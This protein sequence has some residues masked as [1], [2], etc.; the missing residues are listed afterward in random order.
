[1]GVILD[2][3]ISIR[4]ERR[5]ISPPE[6]LRQIEAITGSEPIGLSAIGITEVVHGIYRA[7]S[8]ARSLNRRKYL[9]DLLSVLPV[10]DYTL[11]VARL[12]GQ[13]DGE[14]QAIGNT[15]PLVDLMIGATAL[16]E[17]FS[18]LTV[19]PR[20]FRMIPGLDVISF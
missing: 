4:G 14:R 5:K 1:M 9:D 8:V 20:H 10:Y 12:T 7:D 6:L 2:S 17:G 18:I 11:D 16:L 15:I 19:N 13:I 3:S